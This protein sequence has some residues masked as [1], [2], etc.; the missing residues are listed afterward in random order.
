MR[1]RTNIFNFAKNFPLCILF[2]YESREAAVKKIPIRE[3]GLVG[4]LFR[5]GNP[6]SAVIVLGGSSGGLKEERAEQLAAHGFATLALAYFATES[7]PAT[8]S[9]IPLEY[10]EAA[11]RFLLADVESVGLWGV[12][13]GA[14]LSLILGTLFPAQ[15]HA[16]AAHV[17]S[18]AVYGVLDGRNQPAWVYRGKPFA[19]SAPF[20]YS[21]RASGENAASAIA[22]APSFLDSMEDK[23]SFAASA[24]P[25][26]KIECPLLLI[27]A[28][29][30]QMWPSS[31]F[32]QQIV[33]RLSKHNSPIFYIHL[34]YA[35]VGHAP[36]KGA[37]GFHPVMKRWFAFGGN[38]VDNAFAARDWVD[39]TALFFKKCLS[40]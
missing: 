31:L 20:T 12:S 19:P 35:G 8:L 14:E 6:S 13:R 9:Q 26:E 17:P 10:F 27:S 34:S 18:S 39:Q 22:A 29:D 33:D 25:V 37:V 28:Q 11:I 30:D 21:A 15:I 36:E 38:P 32:A 24:I 23:A 40:H 16:I 3:Q 4:T 2:L 1:F 7:L 5:K